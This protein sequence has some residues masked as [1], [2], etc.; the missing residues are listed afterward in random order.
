MYKGNCEIKCPGQINQPE[1]AESLSPSAALFGVS[2]RTGSAT[3][4]DD[5]VC[6]KHRQNY[7]SKDEPELLVQLVA[8]GGHNVTICP[9]NR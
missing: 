9:R 2:V 4:L 5:K 8:L 7:Q 1:D 6:N 3:E